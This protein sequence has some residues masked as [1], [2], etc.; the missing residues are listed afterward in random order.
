LMCP[1]AVRRLFFCALAAGLALPFEEALA[2][3]SCS[4]GGDEPV[5]LYPNESL[6]L[7]A[8]L[9]RTFASTY[10]KSDGTKGQSSG[11]Q[12][13]D[14]LAVGVGRALS[15][16]SYISLGF[17]LVRNQGAHGAAWGFGDLLLAGRTTL[18]AASFVAPTVPQLQLLWGYKSAL[19][20]SEFDSSREDGLD[21]FGGGFDEA[22]LGLDAW[23]GLRALKAGAALVGLMPLSRVVAG[24]TLSPAPTLR[25]WLTTGYDF[26]D[27]FVVLLSVVRDLQGELR[28]DSV[29]QGP[30][31]TK[32]ATSVAASAALRCSDTEVLRL[33]YGLLAA[34]GSYNANRAHR[35]S[36]TYLRAW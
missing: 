16:R 20:R 23:F 3:A 9:S 34:Q 18:V 28:R 27:R 10:F 2:C 7:L 30:Q 14:N 22:R 33:G 25:A 32:S 8:T 5:L 1:E 6:K 24:S 26:T 21:A 11:P 13:Q 17:P 12:A 36:L 29:P 35:V 4:I 31:S 19:G 15:Q